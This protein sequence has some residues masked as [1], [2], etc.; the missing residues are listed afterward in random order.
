MIMSNSID[1]PEKFYIYLASSYK[2]KLEDDARQFELLK[3]DNHVNIND[4]LNKLVNGYYER[5]N[6]EEHARKAAFLSVLEDLDIPEA[7][8]ETAAELLLQKLF[9]PKSTLDSKKKRERVM[10]R[11]AQEYI[12]LYRKIVASNTSL[13]GMSRYFAKMII[14][15]FSLPMNER[16]QIIFKQKYDKLIS[17]I[18]SDSSPQPK[19]RLSIC[20]KG[21]TNHFFEVIPYKMVIGKEEM[22]NYLLCAQVDP[23]TGEQSPSTFH[24]SRLDD[25]RYTPGD[26]AIDTLVKL[27]LDKMALNGPQYVISENVESCVK[28]TEKGVIDYKRIFF[29]RPPR[30]ED[31][32]EKKDDGYCYYFNCSLNQLYLYFRRFGCDAEVV[33]PEELRNRIK[34]FHDKASAIYKEG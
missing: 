14:S 11:P 17:T 26:T 15:Y 13:D 22:F 2:L 12:P 16:E 10:L 28:L 24:L 25:I 34:D 33:Y 8:K 1:V 27:Y 5:F 3:K 30:L 20:T 7:K 6:K 19:S 21:N 4:F 32:D 23:V 9:I 31:R 18:N 29:G